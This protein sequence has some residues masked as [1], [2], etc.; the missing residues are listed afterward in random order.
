[1]SQVTL[2][3]VGL[4]GVG[5]SMG[6]HAPKQVD[7]LY[8]DDGPVCPNCGRPARVP[9]NISYHEHNPD[10]LCKCG[11]TPSAGP[12]TNQLSEGPPEHRSA[13]ALEAIVAKLD[14]LIELL[15]N[16]ATE[17]DRP[18][19]E[20]PVTLM[21]PDV[22]A[23]AMA[24]QTDFNPPAALVDAELMAKHVSAKDALLAKSKGVQAKP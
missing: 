16:R 19:P 23:P 3:G 2:Q 9:R 12:P 24:A 11:P 4:Q 1:M 6:M 18:L 7:K 17:P 15:L 14:T 20:I 8:N 13:A 10:A 22:P 5:L 21:S